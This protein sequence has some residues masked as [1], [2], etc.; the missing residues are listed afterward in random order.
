MKYQ[1]D[2]NP[3]F[4]ERESD[5]L[6]TA[7]PRS[8]QQGTDVGAEEVSSSTNSRSVF[9][10]R[11]TK[12]RQK[13]TRGKWRNGQTRCLCHCFSREIGLGTETLIV[14]LTDIGARWMDGQLAASSLWCRTRSLVLAY[15]CR[16]VFG[17][18]DQLN[19]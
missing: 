19:V 16:D 1:I 2:L 9:I 11:A 15:G 3:A 5:A 17:I 13:P 18:H 12:R 6:T 8:R 4:L 14:A 10:D 7:P